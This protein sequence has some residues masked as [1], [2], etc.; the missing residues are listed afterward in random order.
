MTIDDIRKK[1]ITIVNEYPI[2][3]IVLFG[4]RATGSNGAESDVDLIVEFFS[5]ITLLTLSRMRI[6]LEEILGVDVDLVHGPLQETDLLEIGK[7]VE[8]YAA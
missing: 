7:M 2:K 3:K 1:V 8:L 6:Q 5:P 4:S